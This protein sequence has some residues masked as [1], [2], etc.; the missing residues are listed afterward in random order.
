MKKIKPQRTERLAAAR[1]EMLKLWGPQ[2]SKRFAPD[3]HQ[4]RQVSPSRIVNPAH[5]CA[6]RSEAI[7]IIPVLIMR[8]TWQYPPRLTTARLMRPG[9]P[10]AEGLKR[11][12]RPGGS[13]CL[14]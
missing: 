4:S 3:H 6:W 14:F 5:I 7:L 9:L 2:R 1:S 11:T 8:Y 12:L 10:F 13:K